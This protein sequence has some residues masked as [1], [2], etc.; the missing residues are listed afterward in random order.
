[1]VPKFKYP[2]L[3]TL[4]DKQNHICGGTLINPTTILTAAQCSQ[5]REIKDLTAEAHRHKISLPLNQE[6]GF[7]FTVKEIIAHPGYLERTGDNDIAIWKVEL[8][9]GD[10]AQLPSAM[11][12]FDDG[13]LSVRNTSLQ[14]AGW[15]SLW[16]GGPIPPMMLEAQVNV[17]SHRKCVKH[18][19]KL[20]ASSIC[21]GRYETGACQGDTGGPLFSPRENEKV[22][23]VGIASYG[24]ECGETNYPGVYTRVNAMSEWIT[25]LM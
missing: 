16:E 11:V 19:P 8:V 2:W 12:E 13:S 5:L 20:H 10:A 3:V 24:V 22:I 21:A 14:I 15:G 25:T 17:V 1:M 7:K 4:Q 18:Y 9:A 23:L 6:N